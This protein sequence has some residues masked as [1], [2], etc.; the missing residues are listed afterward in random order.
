[1]VQRW[2]RNVRFHVNWWHGKGLDQPCLK[3]AEQLILLTRCHYIWASSNPNDEMVL[4][5]INALAQR[6]LKKPLGSDPRHVA[7]IICHMCVGDVFWF[8]CGCVLTVC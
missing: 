1:M 3:A 8:V 6:I 2:P 7:L 5:E 4:Q